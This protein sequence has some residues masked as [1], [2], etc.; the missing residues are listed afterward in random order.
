MNK[1]FVVLGAIKSGTSAVTGVLKIL[2]IQLWGNEKFLDDVEFYDAAFIEK[3]LNSLIKKR[4]LQFS[5][6]A[7][8]NPSLKNLLELAKTKL[9]NPYFIY[10]YRNP[11]N[12]VKHTWNRKGR[13]INNKFWKRVTW[14]KKIQQKITSGLSGVS[15]VLLLT[16]EEL[17]ANPD[18]EVK[19]IAD[20]IGKDIKS[21][22]VKFIDASKGYQDVSKFL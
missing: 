9:R 14:V 11:E 7:V 5:I 16:Y 3:D 12:V 22:A 1:T 20:F 21:E 17:I 2:G 13:K 8:K 18:K 4:N 10:I 19:R 6:W 15:P